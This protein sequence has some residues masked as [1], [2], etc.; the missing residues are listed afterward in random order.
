MI[1]RARSVTATDF[2]ERNSGDV[3][4]FVDDDIIFTSDDV[5]QIAKGALD[6][7]SIVGAP[8][9][10]KSSQ[11]VRLAVDWLDKKPITVGPNGELR[12]V[13]CVA[14][15]FMA[16]HRDVLVKLAETLPKL[17]TGTGDQSEP[18]LPLYP[19]FQ[20]IYPDGQTYLSEDQSFCY[21]VREAGFKIYVDSRVV[22]NHIGECNFRADG[23]YVIKED[24][25]YG[26]NS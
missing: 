23:L 19:F 8:Y 13:K 12:E 10:I 15:G 24:K 2:L 20:P 14:A 6:T 26:S 16:I 1:D 11:D 22:V 25:P 21:R 5:Y 7:K 9:R 17:K 3:L 18:V 4:L